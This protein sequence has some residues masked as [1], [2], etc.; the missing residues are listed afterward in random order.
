MAVAKTPTPGLE[1]YLA[2]QERARKMREER[3]A[4]LNRPD[5]SSWRHETTVPQEFSFQTTSTA[6]AKGDAPAK[7]YADAR[8]A[9]KNRMRPPSSES[10]A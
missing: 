10:A 9:L 4:K 3:D 6:R 5:G 1:S 8:R 2:R 7:Q